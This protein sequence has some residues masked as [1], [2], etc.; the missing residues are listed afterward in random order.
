[1]NLKNTFR[2]VNIKK[3]TGSKFE[4]FQNIMNGD[5]IEISMELAFYGKRSGVSTPILNLK[6]IRTGETHSDHGRK[7]LNALSFCE[8][9][10]VQND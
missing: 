4:F 7:A 10:E 5:F 9:E 1:M 8:L 2:V 6:N 3:R